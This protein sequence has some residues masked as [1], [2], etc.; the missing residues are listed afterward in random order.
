[1]GF[2]RILGGIVAVSIFVTWILAKIF[3]WS[4]SEAVAHWWNMGCII[5]I[6]TV[7]AVFGMIV[8]K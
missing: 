7:F 5:G 8:K 6:G 2:L 1:M 3:D 4:E